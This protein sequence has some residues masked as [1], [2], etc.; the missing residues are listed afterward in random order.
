M[1]KREKKRDFPPFSCKIAPEFGLVWPFSSERNRQVV[2]F[3]R[4]AQPAETH[5]KTPIYQ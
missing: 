2:L 5:R 1:K 3:N 4:A